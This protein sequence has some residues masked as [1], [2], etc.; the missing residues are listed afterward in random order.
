MRVSSRPAP[1]GLSLV[2]AT[3]T[4]AYVTFVPFQKDPSTAGASCST[5]HKIS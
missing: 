1:A 2:Y 5:S 4:S 3:K